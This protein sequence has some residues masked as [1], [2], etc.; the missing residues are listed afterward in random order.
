[1]LENIS[2]NKITGNKSDIDS[3]NWTVALTNEGQTF[4]TT[5][6][7][8]GY[9]PSFFFAMYN[10]TG[11]D[12]GTSPIFRTHSFNITGGSSSSVT[13]SATS[14]SQTPGAQT[15]TS[16]T[17][18]PTTSATTIPTASAVP[19]PDNSSGGLSTGAQAGIGVGVSIAGLL[20]IA[21]AVFF[22]RSRRGRGSP[23]GPMATMG[24]Y[25]NQGEKTGPN[26]DAGKVHQSQ[27]LMSELG[28]TDEARSA[29]P[30]ELAGSSVPS[31]P[32]EHYTPSTMAS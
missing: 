16:S 31:G 25:S 13:T 22:I 4:N 19:A 30:S 21:A 20:A 3:F 1:M 8:N 12:G 32:T 5:E 29:G 15:D 27:P 23:D 24:P 18:P 17:P 11:D 9:G 28:T 6:T 14:T 7:S 26:I 10:E 2:S